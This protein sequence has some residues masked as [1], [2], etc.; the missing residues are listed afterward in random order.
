MS[1]VVLHLL[2]NVARRCGNHNSLRCN[3]CYRR[4]QEQVELKGDGSESEDGQDW[5]VVTQETVSTTERS[6]TEDVGSR[7]SKHRDT[8]T[9]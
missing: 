7:N 3:L 6:R 9:N 2:G 1:E 5:C 8:Y 4:R